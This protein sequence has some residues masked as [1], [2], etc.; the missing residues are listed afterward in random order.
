MSS[1][2]SHWGQATV[3]QSMTAK[4]TLTQQSQPSPARAS[5]AQPSPAQHSTAC[6]CRGWRIA[7]QHSYQHS[8]PSPATLSR[9][10]EYSS[11]ARLGAIYGLGGWD[12]TGPLTCGPICFLGACTSRVLKTSRASEK[13]PDLMQVEK[14]DLLVEGAVPLAL[15]VVAVM[16]LSPV[17]E[18]MVATELQA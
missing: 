9:H 18:A 12:D 10:G 13:S 8:A 15:V 5:P 2:T 14:A 11:P 6:R 7:A 4:S 3:R 17:A 16:V 1:K